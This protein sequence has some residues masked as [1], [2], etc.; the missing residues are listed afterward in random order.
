MVRA[1][2]GAFA[3]LVGCSAASTPT[4]AIRGSDS[5]LNLVERLAEAFM[6]EHPGV[7]VSVTGGGSGVGIAALI[8]GTC[9]L[10][11]S[12]R[13]LE[14]VEALL[15][16]RAGVRPTPTVF[17]RDAVTLIVHAD[18]PVA[19]LTLEEVSALF[20]G[21]RTE[22]PQLG[23]TVTV[24][25]RQS[26]S[27]TYVWFRD[28]VVDGPYTPDARQM[29]GT[30]QI[31]EAVARDP[32]GIGY[33]A[34]GYLKSGAAGVRAVPIETEAGTF[35]P[36]DADAAR[37]YPIVR[38]L[39]QYSDGPPEGAVADFLR[40]EASPRGATLIEKMGFLPPAESAP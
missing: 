40:F 25:G 13:P 6:S 27:G 28:N 35:D 14:P 12:S 8:D 1:S 7:H 30:S 16:F 38:P 10:A 33:V 37:R 11:T 5:E 17:A 3:L 22:W 29:S 23:E 24:Y 4:V 21:E 19:S 26:S 2:P 36:L 34:V 39:L 18:N 20:R 15:A 31:V 32:G 9:D